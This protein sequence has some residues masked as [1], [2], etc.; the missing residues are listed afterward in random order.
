MSRSIYA[1]LARNVVAVPLVFAALALTIGLN[2]LFGLTDFYFFFAVAVVLSAYIGGFGAGLF[3]SLLGA[4]VILYALV[5]PLYV[6]EVANPAQRTSFF[7]LLIEGTLLSLLTPLLGAPRRT[8]QLAP[9]PRYLIAVGAVAATTLLKLPIALDTHF[10]LY[11]TTVLFAA[12]AGGLGPGLTATGL[13]GLAATYFF[14]RPDD[15]R[16]FSDQREVIALVLFAI[17]GVVI[18][19][20]CT[21]LHGA[22]RDVRR[23]R[24]AFRQSEDRYRLLV[25]S[26]RDYALFLLGPDGEV[27]TWDAGAARVLGYA[28]NEILGQPFSTFSTPEDRQAARP[29]WELQTAQREGR[30]E[31]TGWRVRRGGER[32]WAELV[33]SSVTGEGETRWFSVVLRDLTARRKTEEA[34]RATEEQ[35]RQAQK[36]EAVGRLAAGVAHDFN[37]LLQGV[38]GYSE[39]MLRKLG[40]EDPLRDDLLGIMDIAEKTGRLTRQLLAFSRKQPTRP[41]VVDLTAVVA[42]TTRMLRRLV[43]EH[44]ELVV[45]P[46][47]AL[48]PVRAGPAD[49][50]QVLLN[51]VLNARDAMPHGGTVTIET[52]PMVLRQEEAVSRPPL[53]PGSYVQ[54]T[55]TDTG[56]GMT[57]EVRAHLFEPFFTTKAPERGTGL[58]LATVY[59]IVRQAGGHISV[60]SEIGRGARFTMLLPTAEGAPAMAPADQ[61]PAPAHGRETVLLVEDED[62]LRALYRTM[63]R[64]AGYEV[65]EASTGQE[66]LE[67][68]STRPGVIDLLVTDL[69]LPRMSGRA[70]AASVREVRPGLAVLFLS[71]YPRETMLRQG[72]LDEGDTFLEKPVS[73]AELTRT[74]RAVLDAR[75]GPP[76]EFDRPNAAT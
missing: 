25:D 38:L 37:N 61:A 36:M 42:A 3:A 54:L 41:E 73:F 1:N 56:Q 4:V 48:A 13:A 27:S 66:T 72:L 68:L 8:L 76:R 59:G 67:A 18:T 15:P 11:Y 31:A 20:I 44:I 5:P 12:L 62:A 35:L 23:S 58:G 70:L 28:P 26:V 43:G 65:L 74:V 34:L 53:R 33:L 29:E 47:P 75:P 30:V 16:W 57:E 49:I 45:P 21:T 14:I 6:F 2:T 19:L 50:E 40:S 69:V 64:E 60:A 71:G 10:L 17:E 24:L 52:A 22:R 32:L 39:L 51:L 46:G 55:V 9:L 63:L 7:L